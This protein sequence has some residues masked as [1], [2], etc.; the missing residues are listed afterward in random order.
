M[1]RGGPLKRKTKLRAKSPLRRYTELR[2][3]PR[4]S[5]G[6][7]GERSAA[8]VI[9]P[10][11]V[12]SA[13]RRPRT[14]HRVARQVR[15]LVRAR[16]GGVCEVQLAGCRWWSSQLQHRITQKSGGRHGKAVARS[17][18]ASNVLDS[19]WWCHSVIT[20]SPGASKQEGWSLEEW[21]EPSQEPVLYRGEPVY[22]DDEG[23]VHSFE[24]VGA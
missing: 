11:K 3:T 13:K 15:E 6:T 20:D 16:S 22:L 24:E 4:V 7:S 9:Q 8:S 14:G 1:K 12:V 2:S 18:R 19:C 10:T 23:L 5:T 17:D 21:Q